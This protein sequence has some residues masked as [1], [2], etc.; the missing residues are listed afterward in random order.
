MDWKMERPWLTGMVWGQNLYGNSKKPQ[1]LSTVNQ[2]AFRNEKQTEICP[3]QSVDNGI[4][5]V[6]DN[7][8]SMEAGPLT[9]FSSHHW[10]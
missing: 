2:H 9:K 3:Y 7:K 4:W 1:K 10:S 8:E 5:M 6:T